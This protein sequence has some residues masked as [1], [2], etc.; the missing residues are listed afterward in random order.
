MTVGHQNI[1]LDSNIRDWVVLPLFVIMVAA[2]LLRVQV[3]NLL[4]A[5]P[6]NMSKLQQRSMNTLRFTSCLKTGSI[7]FLSTPKIETRY[8]AFPELLH[9]QADWCDNYTDEQ[10][11]LKEQ[12]EKILAEGGDTTAIDKVLPESTTNKGDD[13]DI[14][15]PLAAMEGMKVRFFN[16]T[17]VILGFGAFVVLSCR[18][19][20]SVAKR[21]QNSKTVY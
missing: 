16:N 18:N 12:R 2:G 14:P 15:N 17:H 10:T 11:K 4:K 9:D 6:K 20:R 1:L 8:L 5:D 21:S 19:M 13:S 3:G 7:H